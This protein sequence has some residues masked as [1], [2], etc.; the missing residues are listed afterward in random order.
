MGANGTDVIR[1]MLESRALSGAQSGGALA[2]GAGLLIAGATGVFAQLQDALDTLWHV[3]PDPDRPFSALIR[4]RLLSFALILLMGLLVV[5]LL[6]V[7]TLIAPLEPLLAEHV[8]GGLVFARGASIGF[9]L[10]VLTLAFGIVF[11]QLPD[12]NIAWGDAWRGAAFTAVL[13]TLGKAALGLYLGRAGVASAYGAAGS[14]VVLLLWIYYSALIVLFGAVFTR[15]LA[16]RRAAPAPSSPALVPSAPAPTHPAP[17]RVASN[18]WVR[19]L[20][21]MALGVVI[22]RLF[23]SKD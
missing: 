5:L 10:I 11:W 22:G 23:R 18:R 2:V 21:W 9:S 13:F 12:T 16:R 7:S 3:R 19:R 14:F 15:V 1:S 8:P 6:A 4:T 20:G 17:E